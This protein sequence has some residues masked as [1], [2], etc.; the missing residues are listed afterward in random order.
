MFEGRHGT[1]D[2]PTAP[3][4]PTVYLSVEVPTV[5]CQLLTVF[6]DTH[7]DEPWDRGTLPVEILVD[8]DPHPRQV[9]VGHMAMTRIAVPFSGR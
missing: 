7:P 3:A 5:N 2:S 4:S 8:G 9:A 6:S 1:R